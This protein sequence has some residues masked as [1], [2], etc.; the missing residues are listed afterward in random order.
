VVWGSLLEVCID[1]LDDGGFTLSTLL[2]QARQLTFS[3]LTYLNVGGAESSYAGNLGTRYSWWFEIEHG[4]QDA[5]QLRYSG[6]HVGLGY[7]VKQSTEAT[8]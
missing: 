7:G 5:V 4:L 8:T 1:L 6:R 3:V 2:A